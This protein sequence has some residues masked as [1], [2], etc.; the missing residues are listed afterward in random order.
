MNEALE[1]QTKIIEELQKEISDIEDYNGNQ[2]EME[3]AKVS[4]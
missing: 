3:F 2:I 4:E 1:T